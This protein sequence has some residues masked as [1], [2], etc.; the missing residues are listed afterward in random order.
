M[1]SLLLAAVLA[2]CP[3]PLAAEP[4]DCNAPDHCLFAGQRIFYS[5]DKTAAERS[6][7]FYLRACSLGSARGCYRAGSV[8]LMQDKSMEGI[9]RG[10][11][12]LD[13]ACRGE[14]PRA[15]TE[16][17]E[18]REQRSPDFL[19]GRCTRGDVSACR[20]LGVQYW[21]GTPRSTSEDKERGR[22]ISSSSRTARFS[23][24]RRSDRAQSY[25]QSK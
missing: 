2:T 22:R 9:A 5:A 12:L 4:P 7:P 6:V 25:L 24:K 13:R 18:L 20:R 10:L 16:A 1:R 15:C 3:A 8:T 23:Q 21:T 11:D 19:A 14:V 17:A